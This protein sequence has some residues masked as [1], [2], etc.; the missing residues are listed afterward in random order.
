LVRERLPDGHH[1]PHSSTCHIG[2]KGMCLELEV[3]K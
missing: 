3:R 1:E 2:N